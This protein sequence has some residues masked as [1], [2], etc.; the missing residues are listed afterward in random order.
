M[1]L[2][3]AVPEDTYEYVAHR[4][5][6]VGCERDLFDGDTLALFHEASGGRLRDIDRIAID[7]LKRAAHHKLKRVERKL[8]QAAVDFDVID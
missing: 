8:L 2:G 5:A 6:L 3:T 1:H 4:L 7:C